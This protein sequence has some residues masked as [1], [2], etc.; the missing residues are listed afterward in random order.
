MWPPPHTQNTS[1]IGGLSLL[2][3]VLITKALIEHL[4]SFH[5][6]FFHNDSLLFSLG[7]LI[8]KQSVPASLFSFSLKGYKTTF[9]ESCQGTIQSKIDDVKR[10]R[11][12][13]TFAYGH[14]GTEAI[15]Q[16][17]YYYDYSK[18]LLPQLLKKCIYHD[19]LP[20]QSAIRKLSMFMVY[21][22]KIYL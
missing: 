20:S 11:F 9:N 17:F 15:D 4:F 18:I 22:I 8:S 1:L 14:Y 5:H 13:E 21:P 2:I 16:Q 6:I 7:I 12:I 10:P 3:G 19:D